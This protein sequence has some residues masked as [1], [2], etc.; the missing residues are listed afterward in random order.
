M[1]RIQNQVRKLHPMHPPQR[2][3]FRLGMGR[4]LKILWRFGLSWIMVRNFS[5]GLKSE[6]S[7]PNY[8]KKLD[9]LKYLSAEFDTKI[10]ANDKKYNL[11]FD[12]WLHSESTVAKEISLWNWWFGKIT[13]NLNHTEKRKKPLQ[14]L[15]ELTTCSTASWKN[16]KSIPNGFTSHL[17]E[18]KNELQAMLIWKN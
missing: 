5:M 7:K 10:T 2:R 16:P 12:I 11:A 15:S 6:I 9:E 14:L 3:N 8:F 4:T 18:P 13:I 1:G 17:S